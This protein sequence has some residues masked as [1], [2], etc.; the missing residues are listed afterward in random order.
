MKTRCLKGVSLL[1]LVCLLFTFAACGGDPAPGITTAPETTTDTVETTT[2]E[3]TTA[4]A[5]DTTAGTE[6]TTTE[7]DASGETTTA[8]SA[9]LVAP[10]GTDKAAIAAFYN[11]SANATKA[12]K[13]K[14]TVRRDMGTETTITKMMFGLKQILQSVLDRE[15]KPESETKTFVNGADNTGY[16]LEKF[17]PRGAGK[18][19]SEL[20]P[21]G[22]KSASC[23]KDGTGWRVELV[24]NLEQV[25]DLAV[26]PKH[27]T[28]VMDPLEINPASL[29]PF[30]LESAKVI[31]GKDGAGA[32]L[33][34]TVNAD[35]Y[36]DRLVLDAPLTISGKLGYKGNGNIE[37]VIEGKWY[38]DMTFTYA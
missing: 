3:M 21:A 31:Y 33:V 30:T 29:D 28:S 15:L 11:N 9:G 24:L 32:K 7:P 18:P 38:G 19:M 6:E 36:L 2:A 35:G 5:E 20:A 14:V 17:L 27:H 13:G 1:L 16:A 8:P 26:Y 37:T 10:V 23:T 12:Y 22:V 25:N 34:A 4:P